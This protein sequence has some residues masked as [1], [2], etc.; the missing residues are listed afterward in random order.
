M[1]SKESK[2][3]N[4]EV[5]FKSKVNVVTEKIAHC[6]NADPTTIQKTLDMLPE[7]LREGKLI[8]I[9]EDNGLVKKMKMP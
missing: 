9:N 2:S 7:E 4:K 3:S 5:K 6:G 1:C 8:S